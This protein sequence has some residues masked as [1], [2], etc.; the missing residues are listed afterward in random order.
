MDEAE[1]LNLAK[2]AIRG[3]NKQT[4]RQLLVD[5]LHAHPRNETAWLWLSAVV[6]DPAKEREC[7][8]RVLKINPST[9]LLVRPDV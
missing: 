1:T 5:L 2:E 9:T 8:E 7:L 4:A 3:G 6:D